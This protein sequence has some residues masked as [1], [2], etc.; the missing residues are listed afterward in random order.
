MAKRAR[1]AAAA[2]AV[3]VRLC[4]LEAAGERG[5]KYV[6]ARPSIYVCAH[7]AHSQLVGVIIMVPPRG[8]VRARQRQRQ[9]QWGPAAAA[10]QQQRARARGR[11]RP[12]TTARQQRRRPPV[13]PPAANALLATAR[14]RI[15]ETRNLNYKHKILTHVRLLGRA[16]AFGVSHLSANLGPADR[17]RL[18][19]WASSALVPRSAAAAP[20]SVTSAA[21]H[22]SWLQNL[23]ANST[24][25]GAYRA[26][27]SAHRARMVVVR[28]I[29][30]KRHGSL[31]LGCLLYRRHTGSWRLPTGGGAGG[32]SRA[33]TAAATTTSAVSP[34]I[35]VLAVS[36]APYQTRKA[37]YAALP[38][39]YRYYRQKV[40]PTDVLVRTMFL[41]ML[42]RM[43]ATPIAGLVVRVTA[44]T[45]TTTTPATRAAAA[46]ARV[47]GARV[48]DRPG[49]PA[50]QLFTH[51]RLLAWMRKLR[52]RRLVGPTSIP[53]AERRPPL[54]GGRGRGRRA[55]AVWYGRAFPRRSFTAANRGTHDY[56]A[57][58]RRE[59]V[60][61]TALWKVAEARPTAVERAAERSR[62]YCHGY[63]HNS[64][65]VLG[66]P[67]FAGG[68]PAGRGMSGWRLASGVAEQQACFGRVVASAIQRG[69]V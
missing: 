12:T 60:Q 36:V 31:V 3:A 28:D 5:G 9:R 53:A 8:A 68:L 14:R 17:T 47:G 18:A 61:D 65:D 29:R 30:A 44:T 4:V 22:L 45:T 42:A 10:A 39:T 49:T 13:R 26:A 64:R 55:A 35:E 63:R 43:Q 37:L 23:L 56:D 15:S 67:I 34:V 54:V 6:R 66:A 32:G 16:W 19:A 58:L 52:L 20:P 7:A 59:I 62:R 25:P 1:A 51:T 21:E 69:A 40:P 27:D 33:P 2:A 50:A 11:R 57:A 38:P 46:T 41:Y 48:A 24:D